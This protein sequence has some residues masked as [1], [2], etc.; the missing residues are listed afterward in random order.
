MINKVLNSV[1]ICHTSGICESAINESK[2]LLIYC[3]NGSLM[4][5]LHISLALKNIQV[6]LQYVLINLLNSLIQILLRIIK[7]KYSSTVLEILKE[8]VTTF[9]GRRFVQG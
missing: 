8:K 4:Y 5:Q 2:H 7:D 3:F 1:M 9:L 6:T